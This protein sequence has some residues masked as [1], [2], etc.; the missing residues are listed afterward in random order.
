MAAQTPVVE[1]RVLR[2]GVLIHAG[3]IVGIARRQYNMLAETHPDDRVTMLKVIITTMMDRK[4][5]PR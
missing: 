3:Y 5:R 2:N 1:Y 4:P